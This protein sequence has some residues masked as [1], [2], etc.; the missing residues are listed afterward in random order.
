MKRILTCGCD[1]DIARDENGNPICPIHGC[2]EV[3]EEKLEELLK[4]RKAK[5]AYCGSICD[6]LH[7][8]GYSGF[9]PFFEHRPEEE[10]DRYYCGCRGW[11]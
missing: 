10:F 6:S 9:P 3:Q 11:D 8:P 4:G 7:C 2:G 5:C 1:A